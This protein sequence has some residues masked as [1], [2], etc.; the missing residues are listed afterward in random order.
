ML[1]MRT[2]PAGFIAPCLPTKADTLPSGGLWIH[3]IKHDGFRLIAR[4][5]GSQVRLYSRPGNDLTHRFPLIVETLAR[6]RSR[7]C[8]IDGEA[9]A[10]DDN[11]VAS[12]DLI[13]HQRANESIFLYAFDLIE[14]NG[15]D[16]R[17]D[18][19][20]VRKAAL[21]SIVAKASS[22]IRFNEHIEGDGPTVFAH[23]CKMGRVEAEGFI[24]PF[25]P[26]ARLGQN[27]EC[28][29]AGSEA[30]RRGRLGRQSDGA[31]EIV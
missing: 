16:L 3:E 24:L 27:E 8:I 9:V 25:R 6:L 29:C 5:T 4:K 1:R 31:E 20:E 19:L 15:D 28:R 2:L 26:L 11:G 22:G 13:R 30:R 7:S 17:R 23:A 12:F 18:P 21:A 14:Q 10:C